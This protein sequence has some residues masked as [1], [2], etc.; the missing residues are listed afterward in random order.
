MLERV[1]PPDSQTWREQWDRIAVFAQLIYDTDRNLG[2]I[3]Y[4]EGWKLWM[5]DFSRAFRIWG[6]FRSPESVTR[7]DRQLL[8]RLRQLTEEDVERKIGQHLTPGEIS[9]SMERRDELVAHV[10]RLIAQK[11][12]HIVLY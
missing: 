6:E 10:E 11:G 5:I 12:E 4:T 8:E 1:F 9:A 3:L 2:N 7:C